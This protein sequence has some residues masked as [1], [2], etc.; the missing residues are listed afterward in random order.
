MMMVTGRG[1]VLNTA[2]VEP[3]STVAI[4]G[5]GTVGLAVC[6][7]PHRIIFIV[8]GGCKMRSCMFLALSDTPF[9]SQQVHCYCLREEVILWPVKSITPLQ[10]VSVVT[11][12]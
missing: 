10:R 2:K 5:L 1:A 11:G 12:L 3:G 7:S 4:F 6:S 8:Y 9:A